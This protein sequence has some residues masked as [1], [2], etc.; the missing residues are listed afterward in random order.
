MEGVV[1]ALSVVALLVLLSPLWMLLLTF[2]VLVPL[3]FFAPPA[4][5]VSRTSLDCPFSKRRANVA[6]LTA[7]GARTPA[8]VLACSV[9][10]D[11]RDARCAKRCRELVE[12]RSTPSTMVPR[13][14]L[15]ADGEAYRAA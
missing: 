3:S 14:A 7:P 8:D 11:E 9:F 12:T 5:T 13:Y 2:F 1:T 4:P 10:P 6:F 15:L